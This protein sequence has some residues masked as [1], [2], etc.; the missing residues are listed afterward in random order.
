MTRIRM[1]Q[2]PFRKH[3]CLIILKILQQKKEIFQIKSSDMF[4]SSAQKIV[5]TR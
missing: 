4:H 3:A 2:L 5:G 1:A